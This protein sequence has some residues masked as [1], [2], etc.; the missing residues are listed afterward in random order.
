MG[1]DERESRT[2]FCS[3]CFPFATSPAVTLGEVP[4]W[5]FVPHRA[6]VGRILKG[7]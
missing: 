2:A 7:D 5:S 6:K 4:A 1:G 3:R